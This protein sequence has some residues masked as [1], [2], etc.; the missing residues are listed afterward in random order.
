MKEQVDLIDAVLDHEGLRLLGVGGRGKGEEEDEGFCGG[1]QGDGTK[2]N[3]HR[4]LP[5]RNADLAG[6]G[7]TFRRRLSKVA[8]G[9]AGAEFSLGFE[10]LE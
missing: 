1:H 9:G 4:G 3:V 10:R 8:F 7:M 6:A 5:R 2:K